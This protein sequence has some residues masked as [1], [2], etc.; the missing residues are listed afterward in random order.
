MRKGKL[1]H[2]GHGG[3]KKHHGRKKSHRKHGRK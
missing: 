3:R 1:E 2:M